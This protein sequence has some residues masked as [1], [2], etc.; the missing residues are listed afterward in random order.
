MTA[1]FAAASAFPEP[2]YESYRLLATQPAREVDEVDPHTVDFESWMYVGDPLAEAALAAVRAGGHRD[3]NI[4]STIRRLADE[5][6][7]A[8]RALLRD[9]ET[10]PAWVDF[11]TMRVGAEFAARHPIGNLLGLFCAMP[12]SFTTVNTAKVLVR[13]SNL[14]RAVPRRVFET[15]SLFVAALDVDGMR[16]G[17]AG[18][19][20]VLRIRMMH[21][22]VRVG[23]LRSGNWESNGVMP[24]AA[25]ETALG[26]YFFGTLRYRAIVEVAGVVAHDAMDGFHMMWRY[27]S[28][29]LGAPPELV[30][31][32]TA[33][34]HIIEARA[35]RWSYSPTDDSIMLTQALL[36]GLP[37][38]K[39]GPPLRTPMVHALLRR[40]LRPAL[41]PEIDANVPGDLA[42]SRS[43]S[44]ELALGLGLRFLRLGSHVHRIPAIR[45]RSTR[46]GLRWL[47]RLINRGLEGRPA[48]FQ[49]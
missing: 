11:D 32:T 15:A 45:R 10:V 6:D 40:M 28:R 4:V 13:T 39:G 42:I 49:A 18:W 36:E 8:C 2:N 16:P 1:N 24:I 20:M 3:R 34:Q 21:A 26:S 30:R 33:E 31:A 41:L 5:G 37:Q 47:A 35:I 23:I 12:M 22:M 43:R 25:A 14:L 9:V 38:M 27:I 48:D 29:L 17:G 44:A 19:E 46:S 7:D